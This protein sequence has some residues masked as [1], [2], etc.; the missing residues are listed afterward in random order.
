MIIMK[1][2]STP[3]QLARVREAVPLRRN[4]EPRLLVHPGDGEEGDGRVPHDVTVVGVPE[5][6]ER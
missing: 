1:T 3:E 6:D 4:A 5:E 2:D